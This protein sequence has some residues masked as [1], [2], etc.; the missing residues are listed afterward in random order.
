MSWGR[1]E[2]RVPGAKLWCSSRRGVLHKAVET[3]V[4]A[5]LDGRARGDCHWDAAIAGCKVPS[6]LTIRTIA[7]PNICSPI[8]FRRSA[9]S[10]GS[11]DRQPTCDPC[12]SGTRRKRFWAASDSMLASRQFQQKQLSVCRAAQVR[13]LADQNPSIEQARGDEDG[14]RCVTHAREAKERSSGVR[15]VVRRRQLSRDHQQ[16]H[17]HQQATEPCA[18]CEQMGTVGAHVNDPQ[19][20][21][22][23]L[24]MPYER[25]ARQRNQWFSRIGALPAR[26]G[27]PYRGKRANPKRAITARK[28]TKRAV[29]SP[30]SINGQ[31]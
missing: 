13:R 1:G 22:I 5:S 7:S 23:G 17:E 4:S 28:C 30:V 15:G 8:T 9:R 31:P 18:V 19:R 25:H 14:N 16:I 6:Q 26:T 27:Q 12:N 20:S 24:C 29:T 21:I 11:A 2:R 3:F 10:E